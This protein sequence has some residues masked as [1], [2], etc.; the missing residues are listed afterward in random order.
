MALNRP[1]PVC[2]EW[3]YQPFLRKGGLCL[4]RC[5][6]CAMIYANP[7]PNEMATG[8]FYD[9]AGGEYLSPDKLESDYAEVRFE[10]ELRLFR[11]YCNRGSVLDV[12]CS[13]GA[14][15]YQLNRR[16]PDDYKIAGTDVST[17]PL[18]HAEKMGVPVVRGD[19]LKLG[20]AG[21]YD[22]ITFWATME[23]LF[24]PRAFL[25]QA[26]SI[27]KPGGL[28]FILA[29]NLRSLAVRLLGAKYRYIF[30]EHINYFTPAT[31]KRFVEAEFT[32][33]KLQSTHFN[34][35]VMVRDFW[36]GAREVPRAE[37]S[38]LLKRTNA[39]KQS[40]WMFPARL[41]YRASESILTALLLG[42][43]IAVV[44]RKK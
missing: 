29:P 35:L 8:D 44:G 30:A 38:Q 2:G 33:L 40:P 31:L 39:Y 25:K 3:D 27:L 21:H 23:H 36:Q 18:D 16:H 41:A 9:H 6:G 5:L 14:F 7:A 22:A 13:S 43:N 32:I 26:A 17:A 15:L 10:R 1:C 12:G 42:D 20:F 4:V 11:K 24:E 34:P 19:F 28:C 37:R